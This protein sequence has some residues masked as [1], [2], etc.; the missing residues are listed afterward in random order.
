MEVELNLY[1]R[2]FIKYNNVQIMKH[3]TENSFIWMPSTTQIK[4]QP[5]ATAFYFEFHL[6]TAASFLPAWSTAGSRSERCWTFWSDLFSYRCFRNIGKGRKKVLWSVQA[7]H[8]L[9]WDTLRVEHAVHRCRV[10]THRQPATKLR[11]GWV[12]WRISLLEQTTSWQ[13]FVSD[14]TVYYGNW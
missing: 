12:K 9:W 7:D 13:H 3:L 5:T 14:I 2:F 6:R 8:Y 1:N 10:N 11:T 4:T